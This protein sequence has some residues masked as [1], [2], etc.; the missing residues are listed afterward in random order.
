MTD[1]RHSVLLY[2]NMINKIVGQGIQTSG[3]N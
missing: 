3:R 1:T 2:V